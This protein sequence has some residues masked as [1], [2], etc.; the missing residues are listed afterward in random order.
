MSRVA[1]AVVA[2]GIAL[3]AAFI[4]PLT[5]SAIILY[6]FCALCISIAIFFLTRGSF[7]QF[8]L[9]TMGL[10]VFFAGALY[11]GHEIMSGKALSF[12]RSEPSVFNA[13]MLMFVIGFPSGM[14][15]I[16]NMFGQQRDAA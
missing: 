3:L 15:S 5:D 2:I 6:G 10:V 8:L 4:A 7:A 14:Y 1:K 12:S 13:F 9:N 16:K 11:L